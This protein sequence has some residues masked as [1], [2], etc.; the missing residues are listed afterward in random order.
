MQSGRQ[1]GKSSRPSRKPRRLRRWALGVV[2][3]LVVLGAIGL[4]SISVYLRIISGQSLVS[5]PEWERVRARLFRSAMAE[6]VP[7]PPA[8][9]TTDIPPRPVRPHRLEL[10][11][12]DPN[13]LARQRSEYES[14][15][16]RSVVGLQPFRRTETLPLA[17]GKGLATLV[18]LN[19]TIN[20]WYL[21]E[22]R[23][24]DGGLDS[25]HLVNARPKTQ[26]LTLD[27]THPNGV[28]IVDSVGRRPCDLWSDDAPLPLA[29]ARQSRSPYVSLCNE[30]I[31]LRI[32]TPGRR[33]TLEWA[34]DFLRDNFSAGEAVTV[35]IREKL[36][37]D[38]F[39][40]TSELFEANAAG[41]P[42]VDAKNALRP[43][44]LDP[45]YADTMIVPD[46]LGI[47]VEGA[48][49]GKM[50]AG[51]WHAVRS[52]PGVYLSVVR[53]NLLAPEIFTE[54]RDVVSALDQVEQEALVYLLAF[55]L[56]RF[57]VGFALGTEHPRVGWSERAA[58][59]VRDPS[60]PGPDGIADIAPL[61]ATGIAPRSEAHRTAAT[62]TGGFKRDH[63]AFRTSE[64]ATRHRGSH[65]GFVESGA[66]LSK[67]WP[68]LAT[69]LVLE[70]GWMDV[71]TWTTEDEVL[72]PRL[73]FARQNG[74]PI[75]ERSPETGR[76][77]PGRRV[78]QWAA[79]NWSGS[80][81]RK[82][83]TVRAGAA[84]QTVGDRRYLI[85]AYFSSAT[86]SAMARVFQG[87]GCEYAMLLDMNA[88]EHTYLALYRVRNRS[89][90]VEHLIRG[91]EVLDQT[92]D[93]EFIPRFLGFADNRDFFYVLRKRSSAEAPS[94]QTARAKPEEPREDS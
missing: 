15:V 88:L 50:L 84:L 24:A 49:D 28:T 62:F 3:V 82:F 93:G 47:S 55:D 69:I 57:D 4:G 78:S 10:S 65:Y 36:F 86:P 30:E 25:F 52:Q 94:G 39:L 92:L 70:D 8:R 13:R 31:T 54:H 87:Y 21:L 22:L 48:V 76:S 46:E 59:S 79:G 85:Y 26:D 20:S 38:A 90:A 58:A 51:G 72:L 32:R 71:K 45:R 12:L 18:N 60:L 2:S 11:A 81:D 80:Q 1:S 83:R 43:A 5:A 73:E 53:A 64:L 40:E 23:Q 77:V 67:L 41:P 61:V 19:P 91:M 44:R 29:K 7:A 17:D 33:T 75:I 37:Q 42:A 74:L 16:P 68:D 9:P 34:T 56:S 14:G 6:G 27:G 35:F 63:G 66:V 89:L